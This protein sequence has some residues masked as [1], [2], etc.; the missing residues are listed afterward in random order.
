[1]EKDYILG[2]DQAE[3]DRLG[4]QHSIWRPHVLQCWQRAGITQGKSVLDVG[5][6]PGF[7]SRD[8]AEIVGETGKVVGLERSANY[9]QY[10]KA[11]NKQRNLDI[12]V[13][14]MDLMLDEFPEKDFDFAWCRWVAC[15]VSSPKM[16]V[17]K[18]GKA[19]KINGKAIFHEYVDYASWK[20]LTAD[21]SHGE[22]V[23]EVMQSWRDTGGEPDIALALPEWLIE[24]GFRIQSTQPLVFP[25][26]PKD[27]MWQW[28][29]SF[30]E[31][32]LQRL[33]ELGRVEEAWTQKIL[34]EFKAATENKQSI[35]MTPMVLEIIAEKVR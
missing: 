10:N 27:Y 30:V 26:S 32:N 34:A 16:L 20:L 7:A 17:E 6:G 28:P 9:I 13:H 14:E 3:L 11:Q 23:K 15:F 2:T 5:A 25:V 8:L 22:F 35:M 4:L 1:M 33:L 31:I 18:I 24:Q 29:A 12:T 19:L 21:S